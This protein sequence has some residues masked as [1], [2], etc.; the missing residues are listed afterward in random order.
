MALGVVLES[1]LMESGSCDCLR[2][3]ESVRSERSARAHRIGGAHYRA[4]ICLRKGLDENL[5]LLPGGGLMRSREAYVRVVD[6]GD[7]KTGWRKQSRRSSVSR[8]DRLVT[9]TF[10]HMTPY[11]NGFDTRQDTFPR[12][13]QTIWW[14][15]FDGY[16]GKINGKFMLR[17]ARSGGPQ[18]DVAFTRG[19]I[20]KPLK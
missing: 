6:V 17:F 12:T 16:T 13:N 1:F 8:P 3:L 4:N 10:V 2:P 9:T 20:Q 11:R 14:F 19:T 7:G 15:H 5:K 18:V